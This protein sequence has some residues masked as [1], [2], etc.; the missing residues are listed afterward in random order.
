M[1]RKDGGLLASVHLVC[2]DLR[3]FVGVGFVRGLP[4]HGGRIKG[5][6]AVVDG[7]RFAAVYGVVG[8]V[9]DVVGAA[10]GKR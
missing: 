2:M 4:G 6:H 10:D 7:R 1:G 8:E 5:S 9:A 3:I